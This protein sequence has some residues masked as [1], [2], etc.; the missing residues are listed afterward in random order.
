MQRIEEEMG[1]EEHFTLDPKVYRRLLSYSWPGN[2]RELRNVLQRMMLL[3]TKLEIDEKMVPPELTKVG[4][5]TTL[6]LP[7]LQ[8]L[9]EMMEREEITRVLLETGGHKSNAA[10]VLGISRPTLD[11]KIKQYGLSG[12]IPKSGEGA[13][14]PPSGPYGEE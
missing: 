7:R 6:K 13:E 9:T 8:V 2:V 4:E 1:A 5:G 3:S 14:D 12:L 11:K 10:K